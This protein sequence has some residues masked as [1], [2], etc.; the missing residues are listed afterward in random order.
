MTQTT[1]VHIKTSSFLIVFFL[2]LFHPGLFVMYYYLFVYLFIYLF[3]YLFCF[4]YQ[5]LTLILLTSATPV[6]STLWFLFVLFYYSG[7]L[8]FHAI[9]SVGPYKSQAK[10]T[11]PFIDKFVSKRLPTWF[12]Y[13]ERALSANNGG[14]G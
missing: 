8:S 7:R 1:F 4:D 10:E 6:L 5:F 13:F 3:I 2:W 11:Q 9:E 12:K 14:S